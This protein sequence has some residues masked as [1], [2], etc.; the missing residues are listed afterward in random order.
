M[1]PVNPTAHLLLGQTG[2]LC[3]L[4]HTGQ[5]R[6]ESFVAHLYP[7]LPLTQN[8]QQQ[9]SL[10]LLKKMGK[11]HAHT[12]ARKGKGGHLLTVS[13]YSSSSVMLNTFLRNTA[14]SCK[15]SCGSEEQK[16]ED[17]T[18]E[19]TEIILQIL[20]GSHLL[21]SSPAFTWYLKNPKAQCKSQILHYLEG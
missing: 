19:H 21:Q 10:S 8:F 4:R 20:M 14:N 9:P 15:N 5:E 18:S 3:G 2:F 16:R 6:A 17:A 12:K 7:S 1:L 11:V 13:V